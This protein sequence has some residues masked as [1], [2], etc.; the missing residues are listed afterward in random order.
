MRNNPASLREDHLPHDPLFAGLQLGTDL[1]LVRQA[2]HGELGTDWNGRSSHGIVIGAAERLDVPQPLPRA[3]GGVARLRY[4]F[5]GIGS[6]GGD[7]MV[8]VLT[9]VDEPYVQRVGKCEED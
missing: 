3:R 5:G 1:F 8:G 9:R 7:E 2:C 6:D 4:V